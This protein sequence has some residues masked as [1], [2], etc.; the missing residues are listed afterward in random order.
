MHFNQNGGVDAIKKKAFVNVKE[1]TRVDIEILGGTAFVTVLLLAVLLWY[2][3][4]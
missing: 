4:A 3:Y 2:L 1:K